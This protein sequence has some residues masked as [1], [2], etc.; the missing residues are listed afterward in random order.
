MYFTE[1]FSRWKLVE[2]KKVPEKVMIKLQRSIDE[3]MY[4]TIKKLNKKK[5]ASKT[6]PSCT[7]YA[8]SEKFFYKAV[9]NPWEFIEDKKRFKSTSKKIVIYRKPKKK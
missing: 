4:A 7:V 3:T 8:E 2:E 1:Y 5:K 9:E 6:I